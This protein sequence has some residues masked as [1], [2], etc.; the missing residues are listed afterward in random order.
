MD[1]KNNVILL[2]IV[3]IVA[4]VAIVIMVTTTTTRN[5]QEDTYGGAISQIDVG[6]KILINNSQYYCYDSD[7][8]KNY[9]LRGTVEYSNGKVEESLTDYCR[10]YNSSTL[11]EFYCLNNTRASIDYVCPYGCINGACIN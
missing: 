9:Y 2:S 5:E 11:V 10:A 3:T 6:S 4:I 1:D 8:G 7:G